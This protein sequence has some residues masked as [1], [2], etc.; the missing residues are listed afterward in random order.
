MALRDRV[1]L[2]PAEYR[3]RMLLVWLGPCPASAPAPNGAAD[4]PVSRGA[5][6]EVQ[7]GK[8]TPGAD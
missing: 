5:Y 4:A 1:W 2:S 3:R 7:L 6:A 8:F